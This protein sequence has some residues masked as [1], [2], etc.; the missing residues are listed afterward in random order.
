MVARP[1]MAPATSP[2]HTRNR[3][4]LLAVFAGGVAGGL[5]RAAL[6]H[7]VTH[8]PGAW[9][10]ATLVA[11]LVGAFVL[12]FVASHSGRIVLTHR[13]RTLLGAGFCGA[14]TTFSTFQV[15][16]LD[17]LDAGRAGLALLYAGTSIVLGL[18]AVGVA[19]HVAQRRRA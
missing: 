1:L 16:L 5:A 14:L 15:E 8:D 2:L 19:P 7:A 12:G 6:A 3:A 4:T 18:L 17:M 10:W 11:N 13:G 9:P